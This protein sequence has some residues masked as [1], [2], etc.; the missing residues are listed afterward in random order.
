M[1]HICLALLFLGLTVSS[2]SAYRYNSD[3]TFHREDIQ[4]IFIN[5]KDV[6]VY[7]ELGKIEHFSCKKKN[8]YIFAKVGDSLIYNNDDEV[9]DIFFSEEW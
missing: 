5:K 2:C 7:T 1:K 3:V 6:Y 8:P 4:R 9:V